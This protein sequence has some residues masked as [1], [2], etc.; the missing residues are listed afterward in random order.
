MGLSKLMVIDELTGAATERAV[1]CTET[2]TTSAPFV[3]DM[4]ISENKQMARN[5]CFVELIAV[6]PVVH[7]SLA[8]HVEKS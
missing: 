2:T 4:W 6:P 1:G 3:A 7:F 5:C 8:N